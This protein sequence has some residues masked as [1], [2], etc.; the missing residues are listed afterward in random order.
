MSRSWENTLMNAP[1]YVA[2]KTVEGNWSTVK[3]CIIQASEKVLGR[4]GRNNQ[5]G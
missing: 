1:M 3:E 4:E 2:S 5:I